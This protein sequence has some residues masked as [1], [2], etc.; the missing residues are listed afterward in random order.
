MF[1]PFQSMKNVF[2]SGLEKYTKDI[3]SIIA[4]Q[5]RGAGNSCYAGC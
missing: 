3:F 4:H 1:F 5:L 2:D